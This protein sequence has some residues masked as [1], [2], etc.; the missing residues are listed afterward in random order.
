MAGE[1]GKAIWPFFVR[2]PSVPEDVDKIAAVWRYLLVPSALVAVGAC[3][4]Y[5]TG[6]WRRNSS[7]SDVGGQIFFHAKHHPTLHAEEYIRAKQVLYE[8]L[9]EIEG[10]KFAN[11]L[12][13]R[14]PKPRMWIKQLNRIEGQ[15]AAKMSDLGFIYNRKRGR[16]IPSR[17][18]ANDS[19]LTVWLIDN[20]LRH[21]KGPFLP[22]HKPEPTFVEY[23]NACVTTYALL[24]TSLYNGAS[25]SRFAN[26]FTAVNSKGLI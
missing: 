19:R 11:D 6:A 4:D 17:V 5:W 16:L 2:N 18:N 25:K 8:A 23:G 24:L 22:P 20:H 1:L 13:S 12:A 3:L 15:T 21:P 14:E 26:L 10:A 7:W 9:G